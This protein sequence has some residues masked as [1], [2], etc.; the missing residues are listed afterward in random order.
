MLR[1][2]PFCVR[3]VAREAWPPPPH[4]ELRGGGGL[5]P[6]ERGEL[7]PD[8]CRLRV[9]SPLHDD[10]SRHVRGDTRPSQQG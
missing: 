1:R 9:A 5:A 8:G 4:G 3:D 2:Q 10:T 6:G 7:P